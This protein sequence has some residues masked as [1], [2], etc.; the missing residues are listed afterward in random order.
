[1]RTEAEVNGS[2]SVIDQPQP[3]ALGQL[4]LRSATNTVR[5][6]VAEYVGLCA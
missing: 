5:E 4:K 2:I 3:A 1:M 6:S